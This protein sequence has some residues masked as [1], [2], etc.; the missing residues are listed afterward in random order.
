MRLRDCPYF[1]VT[2]VE[3]PLTIRYS[4]TRGVLPG[5]ITFTMA[6]QRVWSPSLIDIE[7][8]FNDFNYRF[9]QCAVANVTEMYS[10][11]GIYWQVTALDR[12]WKWQ[13][14]TISGIYNKW[15]ENGAVWNK[16][17]KTPQELL[18]I[19]FKEL[20]ESNF[21]VS[22]VPNKKD[23]RPECNWSN[24]SI[25]MEMDNLAQAL[26]CVIIHELDDTY[27]VVP[28]GTGDA[29]EINEGTDTYTRGLTLPVGPDA[30]HAAFRSRREVDLRLKGVAL[31]DDGTL[32][33]LLKASYMPDG[34]W[35]GQYPGEFSG[36]YDKTKSRYKQELARLSVWRYFQISY[37]DKKG[38][39]LKIPGYSGPPPSSLEEILPVFTE[40]VAYKS[41]LPGNDFYN[42]RS[43]PTIWGRHCNGSIGSRIKLD[44]DA[45]D[46]SKKA[47]EK[48][49]FDV[50]DS[51]VQ[52]I[53]FQLD[54]ERGLFIFDEPIFAWDDTTDVETGEP[55]G[56]C[57]PELTARLS[58]TVRDPKTLGEIWHLEKRDRNVPKRGGAPKLIQVED[59]TADF[60]F[61]EDKEQSNRDQVKKVA[62][63]Y[64][65]QAEQEYQR[66]NPHT[67]VWND[68]R[69]VKMSGAVV[70]VTWEIGDGGAKTTASYND[71]HRYAK[72]S[73]DHL[74]LIMAQRNLLE[75]NNYTLKRMDTKSLLQR[76]VRQSFLMGGN[77]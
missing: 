72:P 22:Q 26:G 49:P 13:D 23:M 25:C 55:A 37:V 45:N 67:V 54:V 16:T 32:A 53:G 64:L 5:A 62:S 47:W 33:Q 65:D 76:T 6:P 3:N 43:L 18:T 11:R 28:S 69:A 59:V 35:T 29:L 4:D 51:V 66:N 36:V 77:S 19:L 7:L 73:Y 42:S 40:G 46:A 39:P 52:Y 12:R 21:D 63:H 68:L 34:G 24:A 50:E 48:G 70:E 74:R 57:T 56:F 10:D 30:I 1:L 41:D 17:E 61:I 15:L 27:S 31:E 38:G 75:Q 14:A 9:V 20:G 44:T 2:D 71:R 58:I 8:W 60:W